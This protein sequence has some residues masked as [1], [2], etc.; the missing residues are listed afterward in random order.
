MKWLACW[1]RSEGRWFDA[2][3]LPSC[4]FLRQDTLPHIAQGIAC[5]ASV[6]VRLST[7]SMRFSLVWPRENWGGRN[8]CVE[9]EGKGEK[10]T[11]A[12]KPT[13]LKNPFVH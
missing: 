7:R 4:C 6:S 11:L 3:S 8:N 10:E 1:S 5:V 13:L 12:R 9:G 2:Q